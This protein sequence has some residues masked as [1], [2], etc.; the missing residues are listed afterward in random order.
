MLLNGPVK[1]INPIIFDTL[2]DNLIQKAAI[3]TKGA[4]GPSKF[5]ADDLR[6]IINSNVYG[7]HSVDLR[8]AIARMARVICSEVIE[9]IAS[10]EALLACCL[11]PLDK[12]P[13]IRP[14]GIGEFLRRRIGKAVMFVLRKDIITSAGSIQLCAGQEAGVEAS[15]H[16]MVDMF[17]EDSTSAV[18]Q[19]DATNAFNS[20]NRSVILHNISIMSPEISN[21]VLN[22]YLS[23]SLKLLLVS[24]KG[25]KEILSQVG[26]TQGNPISMPFCAVSILRFRSAIILCHHK[27]SKMIS[28]IIYVK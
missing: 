23:P 4:M 3:R 26:T 15:I 18:I 10:L 16:S 19:V 17:E 8:K 13:G 28:L 21:F 11:I 14:I 25:G 12:N 24:S 6:R 2:D 20:I 9:D 1:P 5:D 7:Q 27:H 22:C